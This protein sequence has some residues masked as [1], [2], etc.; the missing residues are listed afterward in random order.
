M[1]GHAQKIAQAYI[2]NSDCGLYQQ[3]LKEAFSVR[4]T[5]FATQLN[6]ILRAELDTEILKDY[7]TDFD[8]LFE[9]NGIEETLIVYR[10]CNYL[11]M[12][13]RLIDKKYSDLGYMS[14][15]KEL[16]CI[17]QFYST[18]SNGYMPACLFITL[19]KGAKILKMDDIN[20]IHNNTYERE[21][22]IRRKSVF[23][24]ESNDEVSTGLR[25]YMGEASNGCLAIRL[26]KMKFEGYF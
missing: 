2:Y 1:I 24:I 26:V 9:S 20:H 3:E 13:P 22:L 11:D 8:K 10:A 25:N 15:S 16:T 14:T 18:C 6:R 5:E 7:L 21:V 12:L 4:H 17:H 23:N 19:P